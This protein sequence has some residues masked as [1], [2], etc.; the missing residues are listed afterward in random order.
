MRSGSAGQERSVAAGLHCG[1]VAGFEARSRVAHPEYTA[2]NA[3]QALNSDSPGDLRRADPGGEHLAASHDPVRI[4][5]QLGENP[6]DCPSLGRHCR[7]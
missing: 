3:H 4:A 5:R 6:L 7:L 2:M 1:H